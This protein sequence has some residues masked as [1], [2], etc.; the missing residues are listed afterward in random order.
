LFVL[1]KRPATSGEAYAKIWNYERN[2]SP[3]RTIT[4]AQAEKLHAMLTG[5]NPRIVV[6]WAM[7]YGTPAIGEQLR[8][9]QAAGCDRILVA[10]LYPQYSAT[11]TATAVDQV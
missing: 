1:R 8:A 5:D 4:R 9:L 2:E 3:L 6:D 7:R 10:P 11:T